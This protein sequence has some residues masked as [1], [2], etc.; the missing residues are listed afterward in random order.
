MP[1][2]GFL[3]QALKQKR[4]AM[5]DRKTLILFLSLM[6]KRKRK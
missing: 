5:K 4:D 2:L 6:K 1:L 3:T